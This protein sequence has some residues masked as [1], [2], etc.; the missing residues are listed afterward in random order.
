MF[1]EQ[2][3]QGVRRLLDLAMRA[4]RV[5]ESRGGEV[6]LEPRIIKPEEEVED[7]L[8]CAAGSTDDS[9]LVGAWERQIVDAV[10]GDAVSMPVAFYQA[11]WRGDWDEMFRIVSE[12]GHTTTGEAFNQTAGSAADGRCQATSLF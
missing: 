8:R 12:K 11:L 3:G 4:A 5:I 9:I 1:R 7:L 6:R 2:Y 10:T